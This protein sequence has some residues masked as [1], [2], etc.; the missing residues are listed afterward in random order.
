MC[1][2]QVYRR[3]GTLAQADIDNIMNRFYSI[4]SWHALN[5]TD[6]R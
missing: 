3:M 6:E 1:I 4:R 5:R 2:C